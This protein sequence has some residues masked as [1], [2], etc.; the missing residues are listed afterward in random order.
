M[1]SIFCL[2]FI[3][4]SAR[5][6]AIWGKEVMTEE[7]FRKKYITYSTID[8]IYLNGSMIPGYVRDPVATAEIQRIERELTELMDGLKPSDEMLKAAY[9]ATKGKVPRQEMSAIYDFQNILYYR[10]FQF[11]KNK[12]YN[13]YI[14]LGYD[15]PLFSKKYNIAYL[16]FLK[17][18]DQTLR[19]N[20][21]EF[22][23]MC[24]EHPREK[25]GYNRATKENYVNHIYYYQDRKEISQCEDIHEAVCFWEPL[26]RNRARKIGFITLKEG[27]H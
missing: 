11:W 4:M 15:T 18:Y 17:W 1:I 10:H 13:K 3:Y 20:G 16:K 8:S 27:I 12:T 22:P 6:R 9:F 26:E 21:M 7:Q 24:V 5:D 25:H 14:K 2:L 23:L 19:D